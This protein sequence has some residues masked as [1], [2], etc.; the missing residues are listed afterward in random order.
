MLIRGQDFFRYLHRIDGVKTAEA[1]CWLCGKTF[2][3]TTRDV[4]GIQCPKC[5]RLWIVLW[6]TKTLGPHLVQ[7]EGMAHKDAE[8]IGRFLD[9]VF[10]IEDYVRELRNDGPFCSGSFY[11]DSEELGHSHH[12][13]GPL[14]SSDGGPT[15]KSLELIGEALRS[16]IEAL[17][18][19][20]DR[21]PQK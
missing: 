16:N 11:D 12:T 18:D 3:V 17:T 7:F 15:A 14:F 2:D 9:T 5:A 20:I 21:R 19:M 1:K 6:D 4:K 13:I 10:K 8:A